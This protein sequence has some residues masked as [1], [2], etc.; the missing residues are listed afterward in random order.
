MLNCSMAPSRSFVAIGNCGNGPFTFTSLS[1][2]DPMEAALTC[3]HN[4]FNAELLLERRH[5]NKLANLKPQD[6]AIWI[7]ERIFDEEIPDETWLKVTEFF[8]ANI[9]EIAAAF[10]Q[11][12]KQTARLNAE[13]ADIEKQRRG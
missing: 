5:Y 1:A 9:T 8:N 10:D 7:K 2:R 11:Q 13:S 6:R 12:D 3:M 4:G